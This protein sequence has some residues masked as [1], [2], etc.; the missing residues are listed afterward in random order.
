MAQ[1]SIPIEAVIMLRN[2]LDSLPA[3]SEKR[4]LLVEETATLYGVSVSTV[5]RALRDYRQPHAVNRSDYNKLRVMP[6]SEM[7]RYCELVAAL[8]LRTTNKKGCRLSTRECIH[9]LEAHGVNTPEGVI[10]ADEGIL[11]RTTV[12]RYLKRWGLGV[13]AMH[14]EPPAV[15]FQAVHSNDCWQF[16]FSPS[17]LKKL[18]GEKASHRHGTEPTLMLASV[19][20]DRSGV[21][22]QEYHYLHGEEATAGLRFLFN[23]MAPKKDKNLP[24]QGIPKILYLDNGPVAKSNVFKRVMKSL[25]VEIRFHMP[26]GSDGRRTTARA[27]GKVERPFRTVKDTLETL[28]H[29]HEPETVA[30][31]N[32]WLHHYLHRYNAM[33]HRS[34]NHSRMEDWLKNL[35]PSGFR[36]MCGWERFCTFARYP[37]KRKTDVNGCVNVNCIRYQLST[38]MAGREVT[39]LWGVFDAE[40]HVECDGEKHGPFYPSEE[41]PIP[42]DSYRKPK[43]STAEKQADRIA[44]LAR[45]ISIPR[46]AL[47][48]EK[49]STLALLDAS[50]VS[51]LDPPPSTPFEE[52]DPL[53]QK[54]FKSKVDAKLSIAR[55]LGMP[56]ARLTPA[57]MDEVN[58]ILAETLDKKKIMAQVRAYFLSFFEKHPGSQ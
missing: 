23:A 5:I 10:K 20:D 31:A 26:K 30:E 34:E 40:L 15:R 21:T 17:D 9:L 6:Q 45:R 11:K 16:D 57:Q 42:L 52:N 56:L 22:Y 37:E 39:L 47:T 8:K 14:V 49:P 46:S 50:K 19:V 25:D 53:D 7:K 32:A 24:F 1:K 12:E 54:Q 18:K 29:F 27:K 55:C 43:K 58:R 4:R 41:G 2:N 3:R 38:D 28:Y 36:Q 13:K 48:G 33:A 51:C 44:E 35:P